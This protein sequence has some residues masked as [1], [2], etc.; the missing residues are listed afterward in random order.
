MIVDAGE[1]VEWREMNFNAVLGYRATEIIF[2]ERGEDSPYIIHRDSM[3]GRP[4]RVD[5]HGIEDTGV[6]ITLYVEG[7]EHAEK[8]PDEFLLNEVVLEVKKINTIEIVGVILELR[9]S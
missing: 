1:E 5:L 8:L 4:G 3:A 9:N 7:E 2:F 6:A